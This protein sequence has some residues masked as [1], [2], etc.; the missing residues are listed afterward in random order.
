MR[1]FAKARIS[2]A[3]ITPSLFAR[4]AKPFTLGR[5]VTVGPALLAL[6]GCSAK[7]NPPSVPL[8]GSYF[9]A[10][11][12]CA[13]GGVVLAMVMRALLVRLRIDA[14][15]PLPPLVYLCTA[16]SG[17]IGFWFVWSGLL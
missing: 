7:P 2:T 3:M 8:F 17:G 4:R 5:L 6:A 15:L 10:W 16:I 14:H 1:N 9:P 11:I 13:L 12:F